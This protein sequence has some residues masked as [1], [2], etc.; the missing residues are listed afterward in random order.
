[1]CCKSS[2]GDLGGGGWILGVILWGSG[3]VYA[4]GRI[5]IVL[6]FSLFGF[7]FGFLFFLFFGL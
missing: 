2:C 7:L 1:M 6:P 4:E 3:R 5:H